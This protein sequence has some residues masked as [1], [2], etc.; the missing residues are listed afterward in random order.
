MFDGLGETVGPRS[1]VR[2]HGPVNR[3]Q[4]FPY[5][6][7]SGLREPSGTRRQRGLP[8]LRGEPSFILSFSSQVLLF[9][10]VSG[11]NAGG[12]RL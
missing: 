7:Q 8:S 11:R 2:G 12:H 1:R 6:D 9:P 5:L 4:W 3:L 10:A